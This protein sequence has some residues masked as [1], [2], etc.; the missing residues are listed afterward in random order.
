[1]LVSNVLQMSQD[2]AYM[3]NPLQPSGSHNDVLAGGGTGAIVSIGQDQQHHAM[4]Q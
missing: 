4:E 2:Q 3:E 1:M